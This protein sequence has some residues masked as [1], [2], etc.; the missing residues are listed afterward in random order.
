MS[1][2][3]EVSSRGTKGKNERGW[4]GGGGGGVLLFFWGVFWVGVNGE[5]SKQRDAQEQPKQKRTVM[6][7]RLFLMN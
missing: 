1:T 2:Y 4:G 6:T 7:T 5:K 3:V